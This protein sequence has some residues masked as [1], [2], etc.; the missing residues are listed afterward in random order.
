ALAAE[1]A[2][3]WIAPLKARFESAGGGKYQVDLTGKCGHG[4]SVALPDGLTYWLCGS[5]SGYDVMLA[6]SPWLGQGWI[7][8]SK[9]DLTVGERGAATVA[10]AKQAITKAGMTWGQRVG[11]ALGFG[12]Q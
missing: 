11:A 12:T 9:M 10:E 6:G 8:G 4:W 5:G 3:A 1:M 7:A 2:P